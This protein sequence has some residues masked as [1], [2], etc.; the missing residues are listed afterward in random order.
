[1]VRDSAVRWD[2][3]AA[4]MES[5]IFNTPTLM[6]LDPSKLS[7]R[8]ADKKAKFAAALKAFQGDTASIRTHLGQLSK[9][10]VSVRCANK[11]SQCGG[12]TVG[13]FSTSADELLN[14]L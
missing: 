12:I 3:T 10:L 7:F 5:A 8:D 9:V 1:M 11:D 13:Q 4:K 2:S 6:L 14:S